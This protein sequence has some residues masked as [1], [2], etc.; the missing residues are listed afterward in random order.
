LTPRFSPGLLTL[1]IALSIRF[2]PMYA[3]LIRAEMLVE[4][5]KEYA[6]AAQALGSSRERLIFRHLRPF[7]SPQRSLGEVMLRCAG[8]CSLSRQRER[9]G[10][11]GG[12]C[13]RAGGAQCGT[14]AT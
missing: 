5:V 4:R 3:R 8:C 2:I 9:D 11:R 1:I 7:P 10:V 12:S 6:V 13:G 14:S